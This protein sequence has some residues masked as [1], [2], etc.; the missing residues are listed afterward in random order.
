MFIS[1]T[2]IINTK[3]VEASMISMDKTIE[4]ITLCTYFVFLFL[5]F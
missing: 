1:N 2:I 5:V 3:L 4:T